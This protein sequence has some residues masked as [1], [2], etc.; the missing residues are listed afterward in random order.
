[1][2]SFMVIHFIF[3]SPLLCGV[4]SKAAIWLRGSPVL[5]IAMLFGSGTMIRRASWSL[6]CSQN[7]AATYLTVSRTMPAG[8]VI[9]VGCPRASDIAVSGG[10]LY[11]DSVNL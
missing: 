11:S 1:M 9:L 6:M 2:K 7:W 5:Q 8:A 3:T 4:A 10:M